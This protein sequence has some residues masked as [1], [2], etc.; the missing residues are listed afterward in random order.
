VVLSGWRRIEDRLQPIEP[1]HDWISPRLGIRFDMSGEELVVHGPNN[2]PFLSFV[3]VKAMQERE[4]HRAERAEVHAREAQ[5][6][7]DEARRQAQ[8]AQ[9]QAVEAQRQKDHAQ[10]QT[11]EAQRRAE[12]LAAKLR[13]L[14]ID[15]EA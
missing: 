8:D 15:P 2:E 11:V 6:Q 10:Q 12:Q 4:R 5:R 13:A 9:Q 3:E 1:M 7:A 14:G